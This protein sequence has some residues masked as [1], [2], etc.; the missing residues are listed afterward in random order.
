VYIRSWKLLPGTGGVFE[1][2]V[3]GEK[4][5]SKKE[6]GRHAEPGEA[7]AAIV[8]KLGELKAARP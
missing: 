1:V 3:N 5:F 7:K 8:K 4:V 6:L 2:T